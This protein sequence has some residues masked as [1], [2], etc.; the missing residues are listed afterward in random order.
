MSHNSSFVVAE[1]NEQK[2]ALYTKI[3]RNYRSMRITWD[4]IADALDELRDEDLALEIRRKFC[5]ME[6]SE[7]ECD[8]V[9]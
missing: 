2:Y 9:G 8:E 4:K 6:K 7:L 3:S 5:K 1:T